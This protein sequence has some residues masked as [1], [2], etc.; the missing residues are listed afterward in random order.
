MPKPV[1]FVEPHSD[2]IV[3]AVSKHSWKRAIA[4]VSWWIVCLTMPIVAI[5]F[6]AISGMIIG[7][8]A[9]IGKALDDAKTD[10]ARWYQMYEEID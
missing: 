2:P 4:L 6:G 5:V 10:L 1:P 7:V 9:G 3:D 8:S